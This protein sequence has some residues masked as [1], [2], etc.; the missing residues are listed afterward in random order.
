[1]LAAFQQPELA[2]PFLASLGNARETAGWRA[3]TAALATERERNTGGAG[4]KNGN[5]ALTP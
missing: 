3:L 1:M 2:A 5:V 4:M